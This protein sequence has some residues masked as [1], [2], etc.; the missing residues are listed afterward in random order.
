MKRLIKLST[1]DRFNNE[2]GIVLRYNKSYSMWEVKLLSD[3]RAG[4]FNTKKAAYNEP[5]RVPIRLFRS[6]EINDVKWKLK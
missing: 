3:M 4:R 2:Y 5:F 1:A 6:R